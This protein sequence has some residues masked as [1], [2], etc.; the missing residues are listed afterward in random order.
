MRTG[1]LTCF[2]QGYHVDVEGGGYASG[3]IQTGKGSS[4]AMQKAGMEATGGIELE[5]AVVWHSLI[6]LRPDVVVGRLTFV[7]PA[8]ERVSLLET[9]DLYVRSGDKRLFRCDCLTR[10]CALQVHNH[11]S[12]CCGDCRLGY[13]LRY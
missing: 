2:V 12:T 8:A 13:P 9:H 10:H 6:V 1:F 7:C 3:G 4:Y 11:L 5:D